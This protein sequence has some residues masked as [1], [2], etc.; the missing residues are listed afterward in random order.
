[1]ETRY[2]LIFEKYPA[3]SDQR[4]FGVLNGH[5]AAVRLGNIFIATAPPATRPRAGL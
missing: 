5:H 3:P 1:M 4:M 2:S